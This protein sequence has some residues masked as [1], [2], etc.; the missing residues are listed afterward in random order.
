MIEHEIFSENGAPYILL[1]TNLSERP[2]KLLVDTGASISLLASDLIY[3]NIKKANYIINLYG[4]V[5]K[6]VSIQTEGFV[7]GILSVS[8]CWLGTTLHLVDR[9]YSGPAD[10]YL[11][12]DFLA[13]YGVILNMN[14]MCLQ[15]NLNEI[16]K[17]R[18]QA[19]KQQTIEYPNG[20]EIKKFEKNLS[21][22]TDIIRV[23]N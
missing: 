23:A 17:S 1:E 7:Q 5:G 19:E 6:D 20:N 4:I 14:N 18:A 21:P 22:Q 13:P 8:G 2:L 15:I 12:Y 11:G 9:K 16:T 10:G 3:K